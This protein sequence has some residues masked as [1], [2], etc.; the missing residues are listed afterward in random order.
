MGR[1]MTGRILPPV[2]ATRF[3]IEGIPSMVRWLAL[4]LLGGCLGL[5][6][7][8]L[9][10]I[11]RRGRRGLGLGLGCLLGSLLLI[12]VGMSL[13]LFGDPLTIARMVLFGESQV[14]LPRLWPLGLILAARSTGGSPG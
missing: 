13:L 12:T 10:L 6:V 3:V 5:N 4:L 7:L 2:G 11:Y 14:N 1:G 9:R 8:G